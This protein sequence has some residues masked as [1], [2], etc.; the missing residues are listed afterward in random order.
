MLLFFV[1]TIMFF[2]A[3]LKQNRDY[4][5]IQLHP[6][7]AWINLAVQAAEIGVWSWDITRDRIEITE[8]GQILHGFT[9]DALTNYR[10]WLK[11]LHTDDQ[12]PTHQAIHRALTEKTDYRN[13]Y[14]VIHPDGSVRWIASQG[15]GDFDNAGNPLR[16][17]GVLFDVTARKQAEQMLKDQHQMLAH[18]ARVTTLGELSAA[19]AHELNQPLTAILCNAQAGQRFMAQTPPDWEELSAILVDIVADDRRAGVVVS[20]LRALFKKEEAVQQVLNINALIEEVTQLLHSDLIVKQVSLH[21]H[22][23][24]D[25]PKIMG[26]PVQIRQV[27]L[28]LIM[29]GTE[30]IAV[31]TAGLRQLRICTG[32]HGADSLE[33]TVH[34]T[35]PGIAPQMLEQIFEPFVTGKAHGLGMGLAISR[36]IVTAHDGRLCAGNSPE[37]GAI[38]YFTLPIIQEFNS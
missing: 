35:G 36:T 14:R 2:I 26:D 28:N 17:V 23:T 13:E 12:E 38:M 15:R 6:S 27:L 1:I 30:A 37:G 3:W 22:L 5:K 21:L 4:A 24:A 11:T 7:D 10:A 32:L 18:M 31:S 9:F 25:L 19:L 8:F 34:D 20:R 29:N 16:L 33:V